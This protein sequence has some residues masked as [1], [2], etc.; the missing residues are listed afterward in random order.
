MVPKSNIGAHVIGEYGVKSGTITAGQTTTD[1]VG[2][3]LNQIDRL[4]YES[5]QLQI[6]YDVNLT[7]GKAVNLKVDLYDSS[8]SG[9]F[10]GAATNLL[11]LASAIPYV[12]A[13]T[14]QGVYNL[15]VDFTNY[16]RYLEF[17]V[18]ADLTN[19]GTDTLQYDA[20]VVIG[21]A[22]IIPTF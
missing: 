22:D 8:T 3:T 17:V 21:G 9:S 20:M 16:A 12:K 7:S 5:G 6:I 10:T 11:S 18:T 14:V 13:G 15:N 4:G 1:N 2:L 19:T